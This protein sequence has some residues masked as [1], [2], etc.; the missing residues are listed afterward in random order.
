MDMNNAE[1]SS[2]IESGEYRKIFLTLCVIVQIVR[3]VKDTFL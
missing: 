3:C 2:K 1:V